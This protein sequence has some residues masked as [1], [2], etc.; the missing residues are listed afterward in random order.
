METRSP[1]MLTWQALKREGVPLLCSEIA[2]WHNLTPG[3]VR[4]ALHKMMDEGLVVRNEAGYWAIV[5]DGQ[6]TEG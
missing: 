6:G 4:R 3:A 1:T 5:I 2:K